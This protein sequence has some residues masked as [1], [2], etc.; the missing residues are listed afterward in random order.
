MRLLIATQVVD[1]DDPNLGFFHQWIEE[2]ARHATHIEVICLKEG[3]HAFPDN[4]RVH[5]LGKDKGKRPSWVYALRFLTLSWQLR[6]T[7]DAVFVHMNPEY[8]VVSGWL[9]R[10]TGKPVALWYVHKQVN[11]MLRI[12]AFFATVI[13]T[14]SRESFRLRTRKLRVLGHGI[15]F[16]DPI[17]R[18]RESD[19]MRVLSISRISPA[20]RI[21]VMIELA[22]ELA[23]RG[24]PFSLTIVGAAATPE[25]ALYV[26]EL[27][28]AAGE[29]TYEHPIRFHG[30][31]RHREVLSMLAHADV[32][33]NLSA[34]GSMDKAVLEALGAGVPV[35]SSNEAFQD[36]LAPY[37]LYIPSGSPSLLA[38]AVIRAPHVDIRPLT[39]AIRSHHSLSSLIPAILQALPYGVPAAGRKES[40][41]RNGV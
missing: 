7:Y 27:H 31:V 30:P 20:K 2:F 15:V 34:T 3:N 6:R 19:Q 22:D 4:V 41:S 35:V 39:E 33:L 5:S 29:R 36:V 17:A 14:A 24:A 37:G 8:L 40:L 10:L 11:L 23:S 12:G 21:D 1:Q 18:N 9:W 25:D 38:D 28:R 16:A 26:K 32:F 13:C